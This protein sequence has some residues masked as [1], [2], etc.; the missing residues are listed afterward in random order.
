MSARGS[1]IAVAYLG[2]APLRALGVGDRLE[3][4]R[5]LAASQID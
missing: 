5:A 2:M 3:A 4:W 1:S